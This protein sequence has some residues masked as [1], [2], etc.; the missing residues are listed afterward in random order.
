M[1]KVTMIKVTEITY[2]NIRVC[3][4]E[5][6]ETIGQY[7]VIIEI[8]EH[9]RALSIIVDNIAYPDFKIHKWFTRLDAY[10]SLACGRGDIKLWLE[11]QIT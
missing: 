9:G 2:P 6:N 8:D 4:A 7:P 1:I 5:T 11:H 3:V 10:A